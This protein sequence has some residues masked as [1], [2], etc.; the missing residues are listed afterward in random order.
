[1]TILVLHKSRRSTDAIFSMRTEN[2]KKTF[3]NL[4]HKAKQ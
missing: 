2:W 4:K 1:M 3:P